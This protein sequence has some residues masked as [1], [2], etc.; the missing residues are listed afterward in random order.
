MLPT[1]VSYWNLKE[2]QRHDYVTEE[3]NERT[4]EETKRRN[5]ATEALTA[6]A[7]AET[8]RRNRMQ[9][10]LNQIELE[11]KQN[12]NAFQAEIGYRNL[13]ENVR[14]NLA[15]ESVSSLQANASQTQAA[16]AARSSLASYNNSIAA[17]KQAQVA[18]LVA[19]SRIS[20]SEASANLSK[21]QRIKTSKEA[22]V[23]E[24]HNVQGWT[25]SIINGVSTILRYL[26]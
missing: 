17:M 7:N 5:K 21:M 18:E 6:Q 10:R 1:Q 11:I 14:H 13:D 19:P 9:E 20:Q 3:Q 24:Q 2:T 4:I 15:Q 22:D 25:N 23:I 12:Y 8:A 26:K 16:A